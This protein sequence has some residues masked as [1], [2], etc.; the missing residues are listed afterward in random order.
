[1]LARKE[2]GADSEALDIKL[3]L[4]ALFSY[5]GNHVNVRRATRNNCRALGSK[6]AGNSSISLVSSHLSFYL[7]VPLMLG[8]NRKGVKSI[9]TAS[10]RI[11]V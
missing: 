11:F 10:C 8:V 3:R 2:K 9:V 4:R 1:M 7:R 5:I 6:L